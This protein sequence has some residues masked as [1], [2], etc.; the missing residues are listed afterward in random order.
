MELYFTEKV[1]MKEVKR[2]ISEVLPNGFKL[3][4]IKRVPLTFPAIDVL[5]N[6]SEFSIR[7]VDVSESDM[8]DFLSQESIIVEKTKKGKIVKFDAKPLIYK[9]IKSNN[10]LK[11]YLRFGQGKNVKPELILK[12]LLVNQENYAKIYQIDRTK[13]FVETKNGE[14]NEP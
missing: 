8:D 1:D 3:I 14:I 2:K 4:D 7:N 13:L 11:L 12:K 5:V 9:F 10:I 6:M